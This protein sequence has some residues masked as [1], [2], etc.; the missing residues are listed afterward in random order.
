MIVRRNPPSHY[1]RH[2]TAVERA[3]AMAL[4]PPPI[5]AGPAVHE[6]HSIILHDALTRQCREIEAQAKA[7]LRAHREARRRG[8]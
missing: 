8:I 7:A 1:A 6:A 3:M 5:H 2:L 4:V